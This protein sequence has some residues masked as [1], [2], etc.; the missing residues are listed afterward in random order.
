MEVAE[1]ELFYN[2][3]NQSYVIKEG[4]GVLELSEDQFQAMRDDGRSPLLLKL[5]KAARSQRVDTS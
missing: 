4:D 3:E 2:R 1:I 5:W